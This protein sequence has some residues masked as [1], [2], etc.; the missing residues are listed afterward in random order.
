[1]T[2]VHKGRVLAAQRMDW[3]QGQAVKGPGTNGWPRVDGS[4]SAAAVYSLLQTASQPT[5]SLFPVAA[6][7]RW[8]AIPLRQAPAAA[9]PCLFVC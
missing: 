4:V 7:C 2:E 5:L 6:V 8:R 9:I 3:A 1:M